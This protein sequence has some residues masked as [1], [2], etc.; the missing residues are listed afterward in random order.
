LV[1]HIEGETYAVGYEK[2]VL[3]RIFGSKMGRGNRE[4]EKTK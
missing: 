3:K 2:G 4:V 1:A